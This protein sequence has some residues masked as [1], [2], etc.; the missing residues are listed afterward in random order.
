MKINKSGQCNNKMREGGGLISRRTDLRS[1]VVLEVGLIRFDLQCAVVDAI[2][3]A[4]DAL[5]LCQDFIV[6]VECISF[7]GDVC[8]QGAFP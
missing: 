1:T 7:D 6:P 2:H 8:C 3:I 5:G 4:D